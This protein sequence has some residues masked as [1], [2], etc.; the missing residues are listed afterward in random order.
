PQST[1]RP[2]QNIRSG[3]DLKQTDSY[4]RADGAEIAVGGVRHGYRLAWCQERA[5]GPEGSG[6]GVG[7]S[8][9]AGECVVRRRSSQS[10]AGREVHGSGVRRRD[11]PELVCERDPDVECLVRLHTGRNAELDD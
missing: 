10:I 9:P 3:R 5:G 1:K 6:E 7:T 4:W 2:Y 8:V 11:V